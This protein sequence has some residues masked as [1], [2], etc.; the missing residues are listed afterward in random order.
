M[1]LSNI[2]HTVTGAS[3]TVLCKE[4]GVGDKETMKVFSPLAVAS[5]PLSLFFPFTPLERERVP[6]D[7]CAQPDIG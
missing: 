7:C 1:A 6:P 5:D 3:R 4:T 2:V